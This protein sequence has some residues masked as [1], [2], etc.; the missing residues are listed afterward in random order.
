[1]PGFLVFEQEP[2][3][4]DGYLYWRARN[5]GDEPVPVNTSMGDYD[6]HERGTHAMVVRDRR[7]PLSE[8]L[9]PGISEGYTIDLERLTQN[10]GHYTLSLTVGGE[11]RLVDYD[12]QL[13]KI[14]PVP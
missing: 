14:Y 5:D 2:T 8:D 7:S 10:D 9:Q 12:V 11:S 3:F 1:M 4:Q 6:I 13:G